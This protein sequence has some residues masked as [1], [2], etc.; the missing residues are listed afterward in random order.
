MRRSFRLPWEALS[1]KKRKLSRKMVVSR[2]SCNLASRIITVLTMTLPAITSARWSEWLSQEMALHVALKVTCAPNPHSTLLLG[3]SFWL[4]RTKTSIRFY[5]QSLLSNMTQAKI[6][7]F[8]LPTALTF[9]SAH[10]ARPHTNP[11]H[12]FTLQLLILN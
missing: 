2:G 9:L 12:L 4:L 10:P 8:P 7:R 1:V 6:W 11:F 3:E 5:S